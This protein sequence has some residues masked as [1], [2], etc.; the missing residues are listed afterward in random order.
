MWKVSAGNI[1]GGLDTQ[2][3]YGFIDIK[4]INYV[5]HKMQRQLL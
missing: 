4:G 1:I 5:M 2:S 3:K